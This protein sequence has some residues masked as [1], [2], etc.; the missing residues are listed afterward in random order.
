MEFKNKFAEIVVLIFYEINDN[1]S[2]FCLNLS[3]AY[4]SPWETNT[5]KCFANIVNGWIQ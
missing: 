1:T 3:E 2:G 5:I 4:S